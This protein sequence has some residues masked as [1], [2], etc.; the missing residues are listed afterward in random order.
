M[1]VAESPTP[2][3]T[4]LR[5]GGIILQALLKI[6]IFRSIQSPGQIIIKQINISHCNKFKS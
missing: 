4:S 3:F 5:M 6:Q 2:D 1:M